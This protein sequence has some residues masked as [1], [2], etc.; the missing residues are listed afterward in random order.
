MSRYATSHEATNDNGHWTLGGFWR[1]IKGEGTDLAMRKEMDVSLCDELTLYNG[2]KNAQQRWDE[3]RY[4]WT[5][6]QCKAPC[7]RYDILCANSSHP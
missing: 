5:M 6:K 7:M 4:Q 1:K 2:V 3:C